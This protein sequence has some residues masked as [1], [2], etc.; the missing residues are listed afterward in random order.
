MRSPHHRSSRTTGRS[1]A[2]VAVVA[3]V[4]G[5][6]VVGLTVGRGWVAERPGPPPGPA[7]S[8]ARVA[9]LP[10]RD[11]DVAALAVLRGWDEERAAAYASGSVADL[12][13]L[14]VPG[15][16]AGDA[17]VEVL[18]SYRSRGLR[19]EGVRM[20][21]LDVAV[22][23]RGPRWWRLRV[24]D[25]VSGAVAVADGVRQPLPRDT[26][27]TRVLELRRIDDRWRVASVRSAPLRA[28]R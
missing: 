18:R 9:A 10:G 11:A 24:T 12:R 8:S 23:D 21:V 19:V 1:V 25:R 5:A 20:Q 4:A 6:V 17:D 15:S 3:V 2:A 14:Y 7:V 16:A 13:A 22:L 26:A 27:T 28:G